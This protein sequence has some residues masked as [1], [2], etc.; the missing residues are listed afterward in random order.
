MPPPPR[1]CHNNR[2][3]EPASPVVNIG[4][5]LRRCEEDDADEVRRLSD[6]GVPLDA[7]DA[8]DRTPV[9]IAAENDSADVLEVLFDKGVKVSEVRRASLGVRT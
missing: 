1:A 7:V 8:E 6:Q 2:A 9:A 3:H 5:A 4:G